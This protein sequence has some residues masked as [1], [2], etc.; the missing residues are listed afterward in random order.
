MIIL[1]FLRQTDL[2]GYELALKIREVSGGDLEVNESTLYPTLYKLI[3]K[4][5]ISDYE[6]RIGKRR[7]RVYYH[8]EEPGQK[9]LDDLLEDYA[10]ISRGIDRI[11][12]YRI[13]EDGS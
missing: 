13:S 8:L 9:R 5:Y 12:Q 3:E 4:Q 6:K 11:L 1:F 10:K 7:I 2:Y